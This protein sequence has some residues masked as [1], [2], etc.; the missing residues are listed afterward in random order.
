MRFYP[1]RKPGVTDINVFCCWEAAL[2]RP[3]AADQEKTAC[4]HDHLVYNIQ[5]LVVFPS[6]FLW[7]REDGDRM[8]IHEYQV[9]G[10]LAEDSVTG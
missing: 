2:L 5:Y 1:A 4:K 9:N 6:D 7:E 3:V 8:N 10:R